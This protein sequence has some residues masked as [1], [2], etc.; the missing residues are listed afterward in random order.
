MCN[1]Y[2]S[3]TK[4][5]KPKLFINRQESV[6]CIKE[7]SGTY[8]CQKLYA[9]SSAESAPPD[10]PEVQGP[11]GEEELGVIQA[12]ER[13]EMIA[14]TL[15]SR[16]ISPLSPIR[17]SWILCRILYA[18]ASD[19]ISVKPVSRQL[20]Q[21]VD[22]PTYSRLRQYLYIYKYYTR[23]F[24][25]FDKFIFFKTIHLFVFVTASYP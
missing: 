20:D 21:L 8:N 7:R 16:Y 10:E 11:G 17:C 9:V 2:V 24:F 18:M 6:N 14:D 12:T 5:L 3:G 23:V 1:R 13:F 22:L 25:S 4:K 19:L 15:L